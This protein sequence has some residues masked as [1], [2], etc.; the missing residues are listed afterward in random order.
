MFNKIKE[1]VTLD[2]GI[3]FFGQ[4]FNLISPLLVVPYI[5]GVCG[6]KNFGKS[7]V[8]LALVFFVIVIIDYGSDIIGVKQVATNIGNKVIL[9][10]IYMTNM[11]ARLLILVAITLL[12]SI[13]FWLVPYFA[14][15]KTL[16][17]LTLIVLI[18]QYINPTWFLQGLEHF[19][20]ISVLNIAS[21]TMYVA[22]IF[23]FIKKPSDYIYINLCLGLGMCFSFLFG[24]FYCLKKQYIEFKKIQLQ[25]IKTF[26]TNG[27]PF[28]ISQI[29]ISFKNYSPIVLIG[30]L[31]G[32]EAAGFFK[33]IEQ[34]LSVFRTY[35]QVIFKFL[36]PKICFKFH[37]NF[38]DGFMFWKKTNLASFVLLT[39]MIS[40]V[41]IC[42]GFVLHFFGLKPLQILEMQ[43]LLRFALFIPLLISIVYAFEQ[44]LLSLAKNN[45]YIKITIVT[46]V[47]N[48]FCMWFLF[49]QF[50]LFGLL[51]AIMITELI[52]ILCYGLVI[53]AFLKKQSNGS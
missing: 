52:V 27:F 15:E 30:Y 9:K 42:S 38:S 46:V 6:V 49:L 25:H 17:Y 34:I 12:L 4:F 29:F 39:F 16:F 3:Y 28:C 22:L 5:I 43:P 18:G 14:S 47:F 53:F 48:F 41:F 26:L 33:V 8:A 21:K 20:T 2:L 24:I 51:S 40:I 1:F 13:I 23:L 50:N 44:L 36:Y 37:K 31:G 32:F 35:L 11:F 45:I 7:S 19:K 10:N